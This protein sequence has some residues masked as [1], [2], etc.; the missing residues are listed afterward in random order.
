MGRAHTT[1]VITVAWAVLCV[2]VAQ[3]VTP[4]ALARALPAEHAGSGRSCL[5]RVRRWWRGP[6]LPQT[7]ISPALIRQAL[8][9]LAAD[10]PV[11]VA[12]DTTRLGGW[13]VWMAGLVVAGRTLPMGWAVLPS[14]W[15]TGPFRSPTVT[16]LPRLQAAFPPAIRWR[17]V[18]DRGFPSAGLVAQRRQAGPGF[19]VRRRLRDGVTGAGVSAMVVAQV[20]AGRLGVGPRTAAARGRGRP[21]QPLV[22]GWVVVR[23]ALAAL[24]RHKHNPGTARERATRAKAQAQHRAHKQGRKTKPPGAA[25]QR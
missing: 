6:T 8:T 14:P 21:E 23:T 7:L 17:L 20:E 19:S 4:A 16:R 10:Q 2:L 9:L 11:V 15:P 13:E 3:R 1:V 5:R 12:R 24:P 18:A 22:P 25:A